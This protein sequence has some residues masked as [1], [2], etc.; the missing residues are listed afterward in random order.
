MKYANNNILIFWTNSTNIKYQSSE[1][2]IDPWK[3]TGLINMIIR[4]SLPFLVLP[5]VSTEIKIGLG[6]T[7]TIS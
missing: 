5:V 1:K 3:T 4:T 2:P 6:K 7:F